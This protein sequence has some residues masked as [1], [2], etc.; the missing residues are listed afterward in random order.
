MKKEKNKEPKEKKRSLRK[1]DRQH[2][3]RSFWLSPTRRE[4]KKK[5]RKKGTGFSRLQ[6]SKIHII[7]DTIINV[8]LVLCFVN[9]CKRYVI[10]AYVFML[11]LF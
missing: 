5:E 7:L 8:N 1:N 6:E 10:F 2:K 11:L 9:E 4:K 3:L